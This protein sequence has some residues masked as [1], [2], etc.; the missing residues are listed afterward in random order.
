MNSFL[1]STPQS[2]DKSK[3]TRKK[4]PQNQ[5]SQAQAHPEKNEAG[6]QHDVEPTETEAEAETEDVLEAEAFRAWI[7]AKM[8][9]ESVQG[10]EGREEGGRHRTFTEL[11]ADIEFLEKVTEMDPDSSEFEEMFEEEERNFDPT[12]K[13]MVDKEVAEWQKKLEQIHCHCDVKQ[14][15]SWK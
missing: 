6:T 3:K 12:F 9:I 7:Q 13:A 15:I 2:L 8:E 1:L 11:N 4:K 5:L 14:K 10:R